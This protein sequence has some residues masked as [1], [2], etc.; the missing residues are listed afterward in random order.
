M[1][2]HLE[3][4][5]VALHTCCGPCAS[6]CVPRLLQ[7]DKKVVMVFANSNIDSREEFER[8]RDAAQKLA[9]NDGVEFVA[10]EYNHEEWLSSVASGYEKEA[11]GA[12]RCERCFRYSLTKTAEYAASAGIKKFTSSLSVSPHKNSKKVFA[13]GAAAGEGFLEI[14]FKKKDGFLL[15]VRRASEL[16]LYRQ[17]YCGCEF[18]RNMV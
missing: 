14:D 10:L 17:R 3:E 15:S 16:G 9:E 7:C 2:E 13:A 8:R 12:K 6:A 1:S 4:K 18:S 11:E 5:T